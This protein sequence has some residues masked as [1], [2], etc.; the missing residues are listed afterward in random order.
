MLIP[1]STVPNRVKTPLLPL[2]GFFFESLAKMSSFFLSTI[3][4]LADER[5]DKNSIRT[6]LN[7]RPALVPTADWERGRPHADC[8]DLGVRRVAYRGMESQHVASCNDLAQYE[9][10]FCYFVRAEKGLVLI[11]RLKQKAK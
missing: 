9:C 8:S 7:R 5:N 2:G 4:Q 6:A 11:L 10:H 1:V 3:V